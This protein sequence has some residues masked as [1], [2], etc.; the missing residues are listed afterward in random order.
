MYSQK[1]EVVGDNFCCVL[2]A[3]LVYHERGGHQHLA[4]QRHNLVVNQVGSPT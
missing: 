4:L 3:T 2:D 1:V